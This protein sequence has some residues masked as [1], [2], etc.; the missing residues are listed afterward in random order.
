MRF[1]NSL[2]VLLA[3]VT[4]AHNVRAAAASQRYALILTDPP[5][6]EFSASHKDDSKAAAEYR[7]KIDT[8]QASLKQEL[9]RRKFKVTGSTQT[10][11]NALFVL[12]TE[13][14]VPE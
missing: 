11:L 7:R 5:A 10:V 14:Q 1:C 3:A 6:A 8:A 2:V 9:E 12:A 4:F 13:D